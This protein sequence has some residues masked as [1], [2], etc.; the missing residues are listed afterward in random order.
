MQHFSDF[1]PDELREQITSDIFKVGA[2]LRYHVEF[3]NPPK[4]KRLI[5]IGFDENKVAL[6]SVLINSEINPNK[7][8]SEKLKQLH[9]ELEPTGRSFLDHKSYVDCSQ[10]FEQDTEQVKNQLTSN[11]NIHIGELAPEDLI[12]VLEKI[13]SAPTIP[14]KTKKKFGLI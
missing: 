1:F 13:R 5:I 9:L 4:T 11:P 2:V 8:P 14:A 3:T 6:A 7:F 10:I 12:K